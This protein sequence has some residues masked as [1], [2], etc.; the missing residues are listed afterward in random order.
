[1]LVL[2][3]NIPPLQKISLASQLQ[4]QSNWSRVA[5]APDVKLYQGYLE[6]G[7]QT[8]MAQDRSTEIILM[9]EWLGPV[10]RQ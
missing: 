5:P 9:I 10:G 4:V 3:Q 2:Q 8:L 7:I 1:M 6:Q